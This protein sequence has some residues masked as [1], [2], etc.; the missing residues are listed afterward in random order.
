[1]FDQLK[2]RACGVGPHQVDHEYGAAKHS[3][4]DQQA[5]AP[6]AHQFAELVAREL[7]GL[8]KV[9]AHGGGDVGLGLLLIRG[10]RDFHQQ[11]QLLVL[12]DFARPTGDV[13]DGVV[14]EVALNERVRVQRVKELVHVLQTQA[15][16]APFGLGV[17]HEAPR[18][19]A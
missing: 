9:I 11:A 3:Q 7:G 10:V 5:G 13:G 1:L 6:P 15:D 19:A 18:P 8:L 4:A 16:D 12:G 17:R 14:V 2:D